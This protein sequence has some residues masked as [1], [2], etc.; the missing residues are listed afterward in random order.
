[1]NGRKLATAAFLAAAA[2]LIVL[3]VGAGQPAAVLQKAANICLEC[4]GVG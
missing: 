4:I 1:M 2:A 3:G